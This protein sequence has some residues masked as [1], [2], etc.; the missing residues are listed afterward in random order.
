ESID[1]VELLGLSEKQF[2]ERFRGTALMRPKRSGLLRNAAIVL[3]NQGD[4]A[5]LPALEKALGD[6]EP[7]VREA[8]GWAIERIKKTCRPGKPFA[9][10]CSGDT[11]AKT[12][13]L[14]Q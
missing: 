1:P 2:R 9:F 4:P 14:H 10:H 6:A 8:A 5:A 7:L 12:D 11:M 13:W 3:G